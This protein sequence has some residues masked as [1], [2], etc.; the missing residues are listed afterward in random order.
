MS[1]PSARLLAHLCCILLLV[2]SIIRIITANPIKITSTTAAR[3]DNK[4]TNLDLSLKKDKCQY[5][6]TGSNQSLEAKSSF[7]QNLGFSKCEYIIQAQSS[8]F[9]LLNFTEIHSQFDMLVETGVR[10]QHLEQ[11]ATET[12]TSVPETISAAAQLR[13]PLSHEIV[14]S[15]A[16]DLDSSKLVSTTVGGYTDTHS[17]YSNNLHSNNKQNTSLPLT[18]KNNNSLKTEL[19]TN[20]SLEKLISK[21]SLENS[22]NYP[23]GLPSTE[24][25]DFKLSTSVDL[26]NEDIQRQPNVPNCALKLIIEEINSSSES[27]SQVI[28]W[29][30][31][32]QHRIPLVFQYTVPIR[33][34][35]VWDRLSQSGFSL[36]FR[37]LR[38]E[39]VDCLFHCN[40]YL[41][42]PKKQL[43]DGYIDCPNHSDEHSSACALARQHQ[44]N[45]EEHVINVI[46]IVIYVILA[47]IVILVLIFMISH[48]RCRDGACRR[49]D[50]LL[51]PPNSQSSEVCRSPS[52]S[53]Q[54]SGQYEALL[55]QHPQR[56]TTASDLVV[57]SSW[58][59]EHQQLLHQQ[60]HE[61]EVEQQYH[62]TDKNHHCRSQLHQLCLL[63]SE[64]ETAVS[65]DTSVVGELPQHRHEQPPIHH[66]P[67]HSEHHLQQ[68]KKHRQAYKHVSPDELYPPNIP[69]SADGEEGYA[70]SQKALHSKQQLEQNWQVENEVFRPPPNKTVYDRDSPPPPY[71]LS[72][73]GTQILDSH[74]P[75]MGVVCVLRQARSSLTPQRS[76]TGVPPSHRLSCH[77]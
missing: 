36:D 5:N 64:V 17:D 50:S 46:V 6:L 56:Q 26:A 40:N 44:E 38:P 29:D 13:K 58:C 47:I 61:P 16:I 77:H 28:C 20:K 7:Y 45:G 18:G 52:G 71:S 66:Q 31:S 57:A 69:L 39:E 62:C 3:P 1:I 19:V 42:L 27:R 65:P 4:S 51:Q 74:F 23:E 60:Q 9:L 75:V 53:M 8:H 21:E 73:P 24:N 49:G 59:S 30:N 2:L 14:N 54:E 11:T 33:I 35:Y 15:T 76:S 43:C 63:R 10:H 22:Q 34:T 32:L 55:H 68:Q 25:N 67:Q 48:I 72:P 12:T 70:M 37:F 41:C